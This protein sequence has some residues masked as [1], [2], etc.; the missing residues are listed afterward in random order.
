MHLF[1]STNHRFMI[2]NRKV[3]CSLGVHW[4]LLIVTGCWRPVWW[5][6]HR[7]HSDLP[8]WSSGGHGNTQE[9]P[10]RSEDWSFTITYHI[11]NIYN[12][13]YIYIWK[14]GCWRQVKS[15]VMD[16]L[17]K[18]LKCESDQAIKEIKGIRGKIY[19]IMTINQLIVLAS[20]A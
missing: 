15:Y 12:I 9:K 7:Y 11:Y 16:W 19:G 4:V 5:G 2:V 20:H 8:L 17:A 6:V 14:L 10:A 18:D 1:L 13:I 3:H